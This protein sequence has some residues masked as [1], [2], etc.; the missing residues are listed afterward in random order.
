MTTKKPQET[1]AAAAVTV[2]ASLDK[3]SYNVGDTATLTVNYSDPNSSSLSVT[4]SVADSAGN[5]SAPVTVAAVI[6]PAQA[7]VTDTSGRT[8]TKQSDNGAVAVFT[9]TI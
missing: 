5:K 9:A 6:D 1:A 4:V 8:W 7:T 3:T 2:S